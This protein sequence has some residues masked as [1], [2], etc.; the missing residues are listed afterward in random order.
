MKRLLLTCAAALWAFGV[1]AVRAAN[2]FAVRSAKTEIEFHEH[3]ARLV[4]RPQHGRRLRG[5]RTG[6]LQHHLGAFVGEGRSLVI[7]PS[8][9]NGG[10]IAVISGAV[11]R[12]QPSNLGF[13]GQ[14]VRLLRE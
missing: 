11:T 2:E 5:A 3:R 9:T 6:R 8:V 12:T 7:Q 14:A 1:T 13:E 4:K 10:G